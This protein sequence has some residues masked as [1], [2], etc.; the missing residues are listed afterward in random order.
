MGANNDNLASRFFLRFPQQTCVFFF[1]KNA[2]RSRHALSLQLSAAN[3]PPPPSSAAK[4]PPPPLSAS[5]PPPPP[6]PEDPL[7][8]NMLPSISPPSK[9]APPAKK[10]FVVR[11]CCFCQ[12]TT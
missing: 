9:P 11:I 1:H 12:L 7:P 5:N 2:T 10:N 6:P 4:V 8:P 3:P